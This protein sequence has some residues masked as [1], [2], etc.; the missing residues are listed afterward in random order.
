ML[1]YSDNE[2]NIAYTENGALTLRTSGSEVLDLFATIG[3][4]RNAD[5][6]EIIA[7]FVSALNEDADL[8]M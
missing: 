6:E 7:R 1:N 3:A 4:L 8:A 2:L 5:E